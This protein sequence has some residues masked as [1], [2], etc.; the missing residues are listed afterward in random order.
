MINIYGTIGYTLF[1]SN[2]LP[3]YILVLSD[4]H[5]KLEYCDNYIMVS[6]WIKKH[7]HNVNILL[8][9]VSREDFKLNELWGTSDHT[10]EL[11]N[12]FLEN[13]KYI[14]DIDIR[15]Y[16]I[17]FSWE[18]LK[19]YKNDLKCKESKN[20]KMKLIYYIQKIN[21]FLNLKLKKIQKKIQNV[22]NINFLTN[23]NLN[24]QLNL[25]KNNFNLFL[26][27]NL[28]YMLYNMEYI[29]DNHID[30]LDEINFI[31]D[32][33]MEWFTIARIYDLSFINKKN[34][35]IHTGL[36]HSDKINDVIKNIYKYEIVSQNGIN[37]LINLNNNYNGCIKLP[38]QVDNDLNNG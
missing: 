12:L 1:K 33:C 7:M 3:K 26:I 36:F 31:L 5:S 14:F 8:E 4:D 32:N 27:K 38:I 17:P 24:I 21:F 11:K 18:N 10:K 28:D 16:L 29:Y 13:Q 20:L 34:I 2:N 23:H 6:N 35:I 25:V 15:P 22:Y 37:N 9:E 30:I 19:I